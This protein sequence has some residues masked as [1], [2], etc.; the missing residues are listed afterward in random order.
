[1]P[2]WTPA[3]V[4]I[5][6]QRRSRSRS[7]HFRFEAEQ[8]PESVEEPRKFFKVPIEISVMMLVFVTQDGSN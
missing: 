2:E 7:Q 3:G 8:E 6:D 5:L 4:C 1:M